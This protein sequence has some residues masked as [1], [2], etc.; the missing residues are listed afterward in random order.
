MSPSRWSRPML[1]AL[2][3]AVI[4]SA[5]RA[6]SGADAIRQKFIGAW[7]LVAIE[8]T[9]RGTAPGERPTGI[10]VYDRTGHVAV[11]ISFKPNR[12]AFANGP[13]AGTVQ[14][15]AAAFDSYGAYYGTFTVDPAA[16]LVIHHV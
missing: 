1:L 16:G 6:Q 14:E 9:V 11:Q 10:I 13:G 8:G 7:R 5:A 12:P 4:A 15:K 3:L 2:V